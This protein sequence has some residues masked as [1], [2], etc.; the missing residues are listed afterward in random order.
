MF[1]LS[2]LAYRDTYKGDS[3]SAD[4]TDTSNLPPGVSSI[5]ATSSSMKQGLS[6]GMITLHDDPGAVVDICFVH[7]LMGDR[8]K[9]WTA[10]GESEP[11]PKTL[12]PQ[13]LGKVRIL[14]Y[15]YNGDVFSN[16][17]GTAQ[18]PTE[19]AANNLL[20]DL[21]MERIAGNASSRPLIL[22]THSLGGLICKEAVL[23]S[24]D[25]ANSHLQGVYMSLKGIIFM[26]TP[27]KGTQMFGWERFN[28]L[29]ED[30]RDRDRPIVTQ[31]FIEEVP[32]NKLG[33]IVSKESATLPGNEP[34]P[35]DASHREMV[36]FNSV[37]D[38]GFQKIV[39]VLQLWI[40]EIEDMRNN[41]SQTDGSNSDNL[42]TG[43]SLNR[44]Q[45]SRRPL[46]VP[47]SVRAPVQRSPSPLEIADIS[48]ERPSRFRPCYIICSIMALIVI[49]SGVLGIYYTVR[50]DRMGDGFTAASWIVAIG[51][52]TLAGPM[53]RHYPRCSCWRPTTPYYHAMQ[54]TSTLPRS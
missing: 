41:P 48:T 22:V 11:W 31:S 3:A 2:I 21:T 34:I 14:T 5:L 26:G 27:H 15:G 38:A 1:R 17:S 6:E 18:S 13:Q 28:D 33:L 53:A 30:Q 52:M 10:Q 23:L 40:S 39:N 20:I 47:P 36:R 46:F 19:G 12:L 50:F 16:S 43:R 8:A 9:T 51:V 32:T 54:R 29:I 4:I 24:R 7:G 35:I 45:L 44:G 49:G 25:N 37:H 42:Q